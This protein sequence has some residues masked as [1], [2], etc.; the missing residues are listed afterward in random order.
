MNDTNFTI[1]QSN[2][3]FWYDLGLFPNI[4]FSLNELKEIRK[5]SMARILCDNS[6]GLTE[7][8]PLAYKVS[9]TVSCQDTSKIPKLDI[10]QFNGIGT[11]EQDGSGKFNMQK[12]LD[13]KWM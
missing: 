10:N 4:K 6:Q 2:F 1:A 3:R 9:K 12:R 5:V 13:R 7:I 11:E 8:Q